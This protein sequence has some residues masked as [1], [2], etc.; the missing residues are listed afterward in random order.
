MGFSFRSV[1]PLHAFLFL[2]LV[3]TAFQTAPVSA[4]TY[5]G[6]NTVVNFS[7]SPGASPGAGV[8]FDSQGNMY[9]TTSLNTV[10]PAS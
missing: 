9:G 1:F 8:T 3:T 10:N 6:P 2:A 5:C 4:Q 7:T